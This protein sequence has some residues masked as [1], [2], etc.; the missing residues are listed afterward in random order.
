MNGIIWLQKGKGER[1]TW[2]AVND[3]RVGGGEVQEALPV[4]AQQFLQVQLR[5]QAPADSHQKIS[6]NANNSEVGMQT[7]FKVWKS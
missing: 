2:D 3:L 4:A 1:V 6:K 5:A 7:F